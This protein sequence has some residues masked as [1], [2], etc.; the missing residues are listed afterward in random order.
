L[1]GD[2]IPRPLWKIKLTLEADVVL[3]VVVRGQLSVFLA[4]QLLLQP[5]ELLNSGLV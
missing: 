1:S 5:I 2:S 4:L 3:K